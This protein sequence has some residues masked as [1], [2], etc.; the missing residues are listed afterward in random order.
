MP[1]PS[2]KIALDSNE[3]DSESSNMNSHRRCKSQNVRRDNNGSSLAKKSLENKKFLRQN[4]NN[5]NKLL[6]QDL[7]NEELF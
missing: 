1:P 5:N 3:E 4:Q 6:M 7:S 2:G